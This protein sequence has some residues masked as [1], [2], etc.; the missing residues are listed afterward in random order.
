MVPRTH[1]H[2]VVKRGLYEQDEIKRFEALR[3]GSGADAKDILDRA[4]NQ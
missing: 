2:M 3:C 4:R 1:R